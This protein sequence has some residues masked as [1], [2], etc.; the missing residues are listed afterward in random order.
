MSGVPL[1]AVILE[2][3]QGPVRPRRPRADPRLGDGVRGTPADRGRGLLP[4]TARTGYQRRSRSKGAAW[5]WSLWEAT[6]NLA[7][8]GHTLVA[9]AT[10]GTGA[11]AA[12][13]PCRDLEREGYGNN[14]WHRVAVRA[15]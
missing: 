4:T 2:P 13:D 10:D 5:T 3:T 8:G 11:G 1:N 6:V 15:E 12:A 9:R 7:P 14:A